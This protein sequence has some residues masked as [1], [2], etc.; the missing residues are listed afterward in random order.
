MKQGAATC[1]ECG[2]PLSVTPGEP[3]YCVRCL[4]AG[5]MPGDGKASGVRSGPRHSSTGPTLLLE[6]TDEDDGKPYSVTGDAAHKPCLNCR[7]PLPLGALLCNHC[8]FH[9]QTG[10]TLER[11]YKKVDKEWEAGGRF[12]VRLSVFLAA[13]GLATVASLIV[14]FVDGYSVALLVSWLIG[15]FLWAFVVGTYPRLNLTRSKVGQVRFSKTWR[16]CFVP[17]RTADIRWRGCAG[18]AIVRS[19]HADLWDWLTLFLLAPWGLIPAFAWWYYFVRPD[20]L[21][22]ALTKE[23]GSVVTLLYRGRDEAMA[24]EIAATV[25][26]VTGLP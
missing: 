1:A 13:A 23:H 5:I 21:D 11:V 15:S 12:Q 14:G 6:G 22:V 25:R 19:G 2:E 24:N 20:Q 18:I 26:S 10:E 4:N 7:K 9:Q 3:P 17:L 8:G 16:C